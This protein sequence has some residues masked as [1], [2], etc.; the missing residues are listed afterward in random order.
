MDDSTGKG[1][2]FS[3]RE[4]NQVLVALFAVGMCAGIILSERLYISSNR[5]DILRGTALPNKP[6]SDRSAGVAAAGARSAQQLAGNGLAGNTA[7]AAVVY[8]KDAQMQALE[9][10]LL[11]VAPNREVLIG[12]SN[13]NPLREGMLETFLKG[14]QQAGVANYVVVALDEETERELKFR[15]VNVFYM[16][17]EISKSQAETGANHAVSA[18]KFGIIKKFLMLGWAVLLSD[19]DVC[20]LQDPFKHLHRDHDLEGMSDGFDAPTA[21]GQIEGYDD[22]S[23]GWARFAQKE[24]HFNLNS[25]LFYLAANPRTVE[26]MQRLETRLGREKYWDQTAYNEEIFFLSH[27]HY[28]SPGVTVRVMSIYKFMNSKVLFKEVRHKAAGSSAMPVMV[29]IN[30]HPDKHDRMKAVFKY[31]LDKDLDALTPFPGG[32][33]KGT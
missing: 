26:L 11:Q 13:V 2:M 31:Y 27:D 18:L 15:N 28:K 25:G 21:Y 3:M 6:R 19:I 30:Y 4:R 33:E 24:S 7:A 32:S 10:Y 22:P 1:K 29:H 8:P 9:R 16:P 20:I 14:I 17:M 23:M 12:V 5:E